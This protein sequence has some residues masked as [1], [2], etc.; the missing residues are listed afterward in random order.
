M[1]LEWLWLERQGGL[2]E[3]L[4]SGRRGSGHA[5]HEGRSDVR[6]QSYTAHRNLRVGGTP[7]TVTASTEQDGMV[8]VRDLDF[9]YGEDGFRLRVPE[10]DVARGERVACIGPSGS[11]KTTLLRLVAGIVL[12]KAGTVT[13]DGTDVS[14]LTDAARRSFRIARI[15]MVF[16]EFELLRYLSVLDNVLLPYRITPAL[17]LTPKVRARA[18]SLAAQV[19]IGAMLRRRPRRLSQGERQRV[20]VCRSLLPE[21][22]LLLA[23]E[24]TGNLDPAN[25]G[26][27]LDILFDYA[28]R[29]NA[30]LLTVTHDH[31]LLERFDR[32][33]DFQ[34]FH[35]AG[36]GG[37]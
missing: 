8:R 3:V 24:P 20:A 15:G 26:R 25:K 30:T 19:G 6:L 13:V 11:G 32:V 21:P 36:E 28:D 33:V 22:R 17:A 2:P 29:T 23:D 5:H 9:S 16:E 4:A 37:R 35:T 10:F 31:A 18:R 1:W 27:V 7:E 14:A 34:Q 12:P